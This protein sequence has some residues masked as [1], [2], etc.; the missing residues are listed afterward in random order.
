MKKQANLWAEKKAFTVGKWTAIV[1]ITPFALISIY[2]LARG[3]PF[4]AGGILG[5]GAALSIFY[6]VVVGLAAWGVIKFRNWR[7]TTA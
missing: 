7:Q 2:A 6:G 5:Q 1:V 4:Y 3:N